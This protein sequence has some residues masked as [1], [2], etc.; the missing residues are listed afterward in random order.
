[1]RLHIRPVYLLLMGLL[2][3][4]M[5]VAFSAGL[6]A[7]LEAGL[8]IGLGH[9]LF[10]IFPGYLSFVLFKQVSRWS[11]VQALVLSFGLGIGEALL[12]GQALVFV[13]APVSWL[14][15]LIALLSLIKLLVWFRRSEGGPVEVALGR[16]SLPA[17]VQMA[18]VGWMLF[19]LITTLMNYPTYTP[20][21]TDS[22]N[23]T[24][25]KI[26]FIE[27]PFDYP[28]DNDIVAHG[29]NKRLFVNSWLYNQ[30]MMVGLLEA[31][32]LEAQQRDSLYVVYGMVILIYAALGRELSR[33]KQLAW[34]MAFLQMGF[35]LMASG[36][37]YTERVIEDK[38]FAYFA[39]I[40]IVYIALLRYLRTMDRRDL[41]LFGFLSFSA[42]LLHPI[43]PLMLFATLIPL[44]GYRWAVSRQWRT[45]KA[46]LPLVI[47]LLALLAIPLIVHFAYADVDQGDA[48]VGELLVESRAVGWDY[49]L[50]ITWGYM[51][52]RLDYQLFF[53]LLFTVILWFSLRAKDHLP[54]QFVFAIS[55]TIL[56]LLWVPPFAAIGVKVLTQS[57]NWRVFMLIPVGYGFGLVCWQVLLFLKDRL[58]AH[59]RFSETALRIVWGVA[60]VV[61]MNHGFGWALSTYAKELTAEAITPEEQAIFRENAEIIGD[62]RVLASAKL[63]RAVPIFWPNASTP[64]ADRSYENSAVTEALQEMLLMG[65]G[66]DAN[67]LIW[68]QGIEYLLL[69]YETP[70]RGVV[71]YAWPC[72]ERVS[73]NDVAVLYRVR[74]DVPYGPVD[75]AEIDS[76]LAAQFGDL[77]R[78]Q[79]VNIS[80]EDARLQLTLYWQSLERT[81]QVYVGFVHLLG[82]FNPAT[83][84]PLWGQD[85]HPPALGQISPSNWALNRVYRDPY[86]LDLSGLP[87]GD[88]QVMVGLYDS[89]THERLALANADDAQDSLLLLTLHVTDD[90]AIRFEIAE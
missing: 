59:A 63:S 37:N 46:Y 89:M 84:G 60:V 25:V 39:Y 5:Q 69:S 78:L 62:A 29:I 28:Y 87:A 19:S 47:I 53:G 4:G 13:Q 65:R 48:V 23:Y 12:W 82:E 80:L 83:Q 51:W 41:G 9:G 79:G 32:A 58:K 3:V 15:F 42:G 34:L 57:Q 7:G 22:W 73:A 67:A 2:G 56:L 27:N 70:L 64:F 26:Q 36:S 75:P 49:Q 86:R 85:D 11:R 90:G 10:Y 55:A 20:Q 77:L 21:P 35:V 61:L 1:M 16:P 44:I 66:H 71:D 33:D 6:F 18:F 38:F 40:P 45:L 81:E 24:K 54:Y 76:P 88:Y 68:E 31:D 74:Y 52:T 14:A 30:A 43:N 17:L 8:G 72:C 50:D